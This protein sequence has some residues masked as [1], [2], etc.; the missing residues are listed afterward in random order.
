MNVEEMLES[1]EKGELLLDSVVNLYKI[2]DHTFLGDTYNG[3]VVKAY[4]PK[5]GKLKKE[6][7]QKASKVETDLY[8]WI[9]YFYSI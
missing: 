3:I 4:V 9:R 1:R 2:D 8:R 5:D 7:W 6:L